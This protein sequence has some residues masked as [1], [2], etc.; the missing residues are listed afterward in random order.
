MPTIVIS[1]STFT[2]PTSEPCQTGLVSF[3]KADISRTT[4]T[5]KADISRTTDTCQVPVV[6]SWQIWSYQN[7]ALGPFLSCKKLSYLAYFGPILGLIFAARNGPKVH[8]HREGGQQ[9]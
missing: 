3:S 1:Y 2:L 8:S 4:D 7:L 5:S 9:L 6:L